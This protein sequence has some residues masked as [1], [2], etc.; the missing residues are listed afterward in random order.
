MTTRNRRGYSI[1]LVEA[2]RKQ[3]PR[4]LGVQLAL[5]CVKHKVPVQAIA[6]RLG[7]SRYTVYNWFEGR[8]EPRGRIHN[9]IMDILSELEAQ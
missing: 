5:A 1:D 6:E 3:D 8:T 2:V 4:R 9:A 7:V